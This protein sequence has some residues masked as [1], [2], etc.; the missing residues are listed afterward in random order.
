MIVVKEQTT[1]TTTKNGVLNTFLLW[2]ACSSFTK[3]LLVYLQL[4]CS[5]MKTDIPAGRIWDEYHKT[6]AD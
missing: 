2:P 1:T 6:V 5:R 4:H 3:N